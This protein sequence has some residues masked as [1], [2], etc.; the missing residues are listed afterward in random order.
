MQSRRHRAIGGAVDE[1]IAVH[2]RTGVVIDHGRREPIDLVLGSEKA[3]QLRRRQIVSGEG[4]DARPT[5]DDTITIVHS[6]IGTR[7]LELQHAGGHAA[8]RQG[9]GPHRYTVAC[10]EIDAASGLPDEILRL[11]DDLEELADTERVTRIQG[12]TA[13][14]L[15]ERLVTLVTPV[16]D[17]LRVRRLHRTLDVDVVVVDRRL[18]TGRETWL[19]HHT[20]PCCVRHFRFQV[21]I[22]LGETE[23]VGNVLRNAVGGTEWVVQGQARARLTTGEQLTQVRRTNVT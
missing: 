6:A 18:Q 21:G 7:G 17:R 5:A 8:Q 19:E 15:A 9:T 23:G 16:D 13:D 1:A 11:R 14:I 4:H 2:A 10:F 3:A 22:A 12:A 20:E